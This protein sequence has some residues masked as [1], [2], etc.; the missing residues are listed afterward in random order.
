VHW[1]SLRRFTPLLLWSTIRCCVTEHFAIMILILL[2]KPT[3]LYGS[4][5]LKR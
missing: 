3:G 2:L 5:L 4:P 1:L